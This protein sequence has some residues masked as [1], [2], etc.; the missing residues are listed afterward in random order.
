MLHDFSNDIFEVQQMKLHDKRTE[1]C[2]YLPEQY[3][4]F[5]HKFLWHTGILMKLYLKFH[6]HPTKVFKS[7]MPRLTQ[8]L[9]HLNNVIEPLL[10]PMVDLSINEVE[11]YHSQNFE[12]FLITEFLLS[13]HE[14]TV[15]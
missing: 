1:H 9:V 11:Q 3:R 4:E 13:Q 12:E 5:L 8:T 14:P 10:H 2:T 15:M 6:K 7:F